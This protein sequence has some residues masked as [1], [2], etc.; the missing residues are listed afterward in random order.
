MVKNKA[1]FKVSYP[2]IS[3]RSAIPW[4]YS[5]MSSSF[6]MSWT[7]VTG[8]LVAWIGWTLEGEMPRPSSSEASLFCLMG[9][10]WASTLMVVRLVVY[11]PG[12]RP[13]KYKVNTFDEGWKKK[14]K[15][16]KRRQIL[17]QLH[18]FPKAQRPLSVTTTQTKWNTR[19]AIIL[20]LILCP[21]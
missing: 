7:L 11:S 8:A 20:W 9:F 10:P 21:F 1:W 2:K 4:R 5:R 15:A 13:E 17:S 16:G 19:K 3:L 18:I 12:V 14:M 6:R